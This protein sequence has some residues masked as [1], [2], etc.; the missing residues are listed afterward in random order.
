MSDFADVLA[1]YG[2]PIHDLNTLQIALT[3]RSYINEHEDA[4]HHNERLEFLGDAVL[5]FTVA[6]YLYRRF[7]E[8][9]EGEMTALRAALVRSE[10]LAEFSL[11]LGIDT[12][13]R[14][15][16]GEDESGGRKKTATLCAAFEAV[17]GAIFLDQGIEVARSFIEETC[18]PALETI[19]AQS[20]HRDA[21]SSFQEWAQA[22]LGQT[23]TYEVVKEEGPDHQKTFTVQC[24]VGEDV[25]GE[26][27]GA[28]KRKGAQ[29]AA[30]KA[31][32]KVETTA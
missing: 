22:N 30:T 32:E 17:I 19:Q 23:P 14:L 6:S 8:M 15:G 24:V 9:P 1:N 29:A 11:D 26:G 10:S 18:E 31:L 27:L 28:S 12:H 20:L 16:H 3:H 5:D 7:P 4:V 13:L 2:I 21:K 25:W